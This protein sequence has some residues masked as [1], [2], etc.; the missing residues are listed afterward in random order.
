[1]RIIIAG[2]TGMIGTAL[3]K[4][5]LLDGHQVWILS[6]NPSTAILPEGARGVAWDGC[7]TAGWQSLVSQ[8]DAIV[9]LAG[10]S[11]G[12][13]PWTKSRKNAILSSRVDAGKAITSAISSASP[14]LKILIQASAVGYYGPHGSEPVNEDSPM[15][16]GFLADVCNAWEASTR[17]VE[18]LGVRRV[19]IRTGVVLS[20]VAGAMPRIL[21]PYQLFVGGPIGDGNQGFP[22]IHPTDEVM[23]IRFLME[24]DQA[25]GV[26][27]LSA[28]GP[29]SNAEFGRALSRVI[30][31]PN[32][33]PVPSF[34]M[35]L[36]LGEMSALVL[37]GQFMLP[38]RLLELGYG[39]RFEKVEP[40][41]TDL[42]A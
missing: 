26:Y 16:K 23:A 37:E 33:L 17:P 19:V 25:S 7:T 21:L 8:A 22:W 2:G 34:A 40:A 4:S 12:A 20:K 3:A 14:R 41:L 31:R 11:L 6:R 13:G 27:N 42:L 32:W 29:V 36:L 28:P 35:K 38:K 1:M 24:N 10:T 39:F 5:L 30:R 15:G 9:N 18:A